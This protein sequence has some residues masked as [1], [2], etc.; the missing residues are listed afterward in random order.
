VNLKFEIKKKTRS[1]FFDILKEYEEI[2]KPYYSFIVYNSDYSKFIEELSFIPISDGWLTGNI[3]EERE[4][5]LLSLQRKRNE[6]GKIIPQMYPV[7]Y[8]L[9]S[10]NKKLLGNF[11]NKLDEDWIFE[12]AGDYTIVKYKEMIPWEEFEKIKNSIKLD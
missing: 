1:T 3:D 11:K 4:S 7:N 5:Y 9:T 12:N 10:E 8:F 6:I 2:I